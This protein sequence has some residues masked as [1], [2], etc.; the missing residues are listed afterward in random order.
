MTK[1]QRK[2]IIEQAD[3]LSD[4]ELESEYYDSVDDSLGTQVDRMYDLGY[5]MADIIECEKYEKYKNERVELLYSLC[6]ERNINLWGESHESS[7]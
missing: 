5:D 2:E 6:L 4:E 1:R 7:T 3:K